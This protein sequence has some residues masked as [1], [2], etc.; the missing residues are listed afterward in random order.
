MN[1][2]QCSSVRISLVAFL[3]I[4]NFKPTMYHIRFV[5]DWFNFRRTSLR[6]KVEILFVNIHDKP[7]ER[8]KTDNYYCIR[9]F[10]RLKYNSNKCMGGT[11][12]ILLCW[13]VTKNDYVAAFS[14]FS[15]GRYILLIF[16]HFLVVTVNQF[17]SLPIVTY[18]IAHLIYT[19]CNSYPAAAAG[20]K[21]KVFNPNNEFEDSLSW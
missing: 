20:E 11:V 9:T 13:D 8:Y 10:A 2:K 19:V 18:C 14:D 4:L 1:V 12:T 6:N 17:L 7:D 21:L 15:T 5:A 16:F 3:T